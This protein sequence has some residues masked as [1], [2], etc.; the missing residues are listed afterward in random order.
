MRNLRMV[1]VKNK[2]LLKLLKRKKKNQLKSF[3]LPKRNDCK[4][5]NVNAYKKRRL[6]RYMKMSEKNSS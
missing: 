5:V 2:N 3:Q 6:R 1:T 4:S